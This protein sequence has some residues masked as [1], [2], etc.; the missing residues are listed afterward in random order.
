MNFRSK[1]FLQ[2]HIK[3]TMGFYHPRVVD[4]AGGFFHY[5]RNDGSIYD[6]QTRHLVSSTRFVFNYCEA[7]VYFA[8]DEYLATARHG[9]AFLR[10][11]HRNTK[12]GGYAWLLVNG[13]CVDAT[14]HC[15]GLAFVMLAYAS[16]IKA[17]IQEAVGYLEET[18]DLMEM[19]FWSED[20]GLYADE[21]SA[22][23]QEV[24]VYRGQNANMHS[25]EA[26][27]AAF[28][29]TGN[30]LY[31]QRAE[32]V[33]EQICLTQ[34]QATKGL[35]WEHYDQQWCVDW[36]YNKQDPKNLFRPWGY[37][38]GHFTEWAKLL[39]M[40]D[41]HNPQNWRLPKAQFLFDYAVNVAW[42]QD[43]GGLC[44]GFDPQGQVCD[45]DKYFWVQAESI[46][47]AAMLATRTGQQKYWD[48]YDRLWNYSWQHMIDHDYGA[49]YRILNRK[50]NQ[51]DDC[52]S[53]AGK[54]DYHTMGACYQ[55]LSVC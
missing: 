24:A 53:P 2:E 18:F 4:P 33:A 14:N 35:I 31:L 47:A 40:L 36:H 27:I 43:F 8:N 55:V 10:N 51:Y 15:Y 49:W 19:H 9:L 28:E 17:G 22:D 23:W 48:W 7:S 3:T 38:P 41:T 1:T 20:H 50:N 29:A 21:A 46:A 45:D 13:E 34:T 6:A 16:A 44:Y 54:T 39:L 5:L 37:Q 42:D 30:D 52:K 26:L 12:T 32:R 11:Q 25:C